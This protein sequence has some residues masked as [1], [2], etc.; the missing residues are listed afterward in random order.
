MKPIK[1][2]ICAIGPYAGEVPW[3]DFEQFENKGLFLISGDTGAGKTTIFDAICFA[4]YGKN[5][6][7]ERDEKKMRSEY[8]KPDVESY[9]D[10][11][12]S[13]QGKN[14]HIKRS[15]GYDRPN[16]RREG[17]ITEPPK[18]TLYPEGETPIQ[19]K[20]KVDKAVEELL[21]VNY[22]QFK[23]IAMIAQG[24]FR[25]M[26]VA[27]S[28][29][30]TD[31]LR[32]IFMTDKYKKIGEVLKGKLDASSGLKNDAEKSIIQHFCDITADENDECAGELYEMQELYRTSVSIRNVDV[33]IWGLLE[34]AQT[35][36]RHKLSTE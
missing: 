33:N 1:L 6:A 21:K 28:A 11:Y 18:A 34:N 3:I 16:L 7:A 4:L 15:P 35:G 29:E 14:Y 20:S 9:V 17:F 25:K 36:I 13:H 23:Q 22:E 10:F 5:S 30:R 2:K 32:N 26:L 24:E 19:G 31:I 8:A 27:S 12:F